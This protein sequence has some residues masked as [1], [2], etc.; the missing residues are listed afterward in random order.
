MYTLYESLF[1]LSIHEDKGTYIRST[2]D[3]IKPALVGAAL[4]ELALLKKI[5]TSDNHRLQILDDSPVEDDILN[6]LL[7]S[8]KESEKERKF[9]Y[10]INALTQKPEKTRKHITER[11]IQKGIVTQEDDHLLWVVPSPLEPGANVSSKFS[12]IKHLRDVVFTQ[13]NLTQRD[14]ALLSLVRACGFLDLVFLRDE[15]RIASR[16]INELIVGTGL[17]DR[18]IQT[19]Q[20]IGSAIADV[21]EDD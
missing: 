9:G 7:G 15:R 18:T 10:W 5:Q 6:D 2:V 19:L 4:A 21:V 14:I 12:L 16:Q 8:L 20:E 17:K 11:L 1:L 13:E 3:R